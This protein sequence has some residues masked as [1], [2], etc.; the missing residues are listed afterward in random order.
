MKNFKG[1]A[2][3]NPSGKAGEYAEWAV[4]FYNG[5]SNDCSYC[6][7]KK[8]VLS[9]NWSTSPTLK[10]CFRDDDHAR[11]VFLSEAMKNMKELQANGIFMSFTTDPMM[12]ETYGL[13]SYV[14]AFCLL[15]DIP[16]QI[17][18]KR[19][20]LIN[21][22]IDKCSAFS[23][24]IRNRI[25][26][27]ISIGF[28]IT[29]HDESEGNASSTGERMSAMQKLHEEGFK[30]FA[31]I[32][33]VIDIKRAMSIIIEIR[34]FCD[35]M[36]IGLLG[37]KKY[38]KKELQQFVDMAIVAVSHSRTRIYFKDSLLLQAGLE[39]KFLHPRCVEKNYKL[40]LINT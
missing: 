8:G 40:H 26:R 31:S 3:Y 38:D 35:L 29:G 34:D 24:V 25:L 1:K 23:G 18:T 21:L 5:C 37:G 13:T 22:F 36:K 19:A 10:K 7:L 33:P 15:Y 17:L 32:E 16:L 28:T 20:D 6:Y 30:T 9:K 4:N 2:L 11:K 39:R 12:P 14:L 27:N